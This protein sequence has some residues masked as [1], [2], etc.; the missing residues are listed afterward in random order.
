MYAKYF[1]WDREF[2]VSDEVTALAMSVRQWWNARRPF[3]DPSSKACRMNSNEALPLILLCAVL[4]SR[5]W[6]PGGEGSRCSKNAHCNMKDWH[7]NIV[8]AS[9]I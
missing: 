2:E 5:C 1:T 6:R 8:Q 4:V 3:W 7:C 9:V